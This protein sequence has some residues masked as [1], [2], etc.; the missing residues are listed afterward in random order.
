MVRARRVGDSVRVTWSPSPGAVNYEV[1]VVAAKG[2][3]FVGD[4]GLATEI[5]L[6]AEELATAWKVDVTAVHATGKVSHAVA[7]PGNR[8]KGVILGART[9]GGQVEY[10]WSPRYGAVYMR[11]R[12]E[13]VWQVSVNGGAW[14]RGGPAIRADWS[15]T[16]VL[17]RDV[18]AGASVRVR[19]AQIV[20]GRRQ[21]WSDPSYAVVVEGGGEPIEKA[22]PPALEEFV[23]VSPHDVDQRKATLTRAV[24]PDPRQDEAPV[25]TVPR[26]KPFAIELKGLKAKKLTVTSIGGDGEW[27]ETGQ[28]T[29]TAEGGFVT[30]S[31]VVDH[32]GAYL[33]RI[34]SNWGKPAYV[35]VNVTR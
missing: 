15:G 17:V 10:I 25:V 8:A 9:S 21:Q 11:S 24:S 18:P 20:K 1:S 33:L 19:V 14:Q 26:L 7:L 13:I 27:V 16:P 34:R 6:T 32:E 12:D 4:V 29:S 23:H 30:R 35:R 22:K 3:E 31:I 28:G 2:R 5:V